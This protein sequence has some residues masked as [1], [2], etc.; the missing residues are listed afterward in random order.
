[1]K[2]LTIRGLDKELAARIKDAAQK[3]SLSVN[4]YIINLLKKNFGQMKEKKFTK[5]HHDLDSLV[6]KWDKEEY[7]AIKNEV[8]AQRKIDKDLWK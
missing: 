7:Q 5:E 8:E 4:Q 1:M 2:V 3:E 6:G